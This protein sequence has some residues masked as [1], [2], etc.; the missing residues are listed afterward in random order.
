MRLLPWLTA[1][2]LA[3][4]ALL[5][6]GSVPARAHGDQAISAEEAGA[7]F[8]EVGRYQLLLER[9]TIP[10]AVG[11]ESPLIVRIYDARLRKLISGRKVLLAVKL[12]QV[13]LSESVE[14]AP[15]PSPGLE[16][17]DS[18]PVY[19][20]SP[21][22]W[23][24]EGQPDLSDFEKAVELTPGHYRIF[25]RPTIEGPHFLKIALVGGGT[26][27]EVTLTQFYFQ[28]TAPRG[29]N[30]RFVAASGL[31][32]LMVGVGAAAVGLRRRFPDKR[33]SEINLL[34]L[35]PVRRFFRWRYFQPVFQIPFL[36]ILVLI[37]ILGF[38]DTQ[39]AGK[40]LATRLTW[41]IWWAGVIFTFVLVGRVWCLMCPY[42]AATE[43]T[44]RAVRPKRRFPKPLRNLW[45]ANILFLGLT[46]VD[47]YFGLVGSPRATAWFLL[48]ILL[49]AVGVGA[50]FPRRS[51][52][53]YVCPIGGLIGLYSMFSPVELRARDK[54]VCKADKEFDCYMGN[55][56]G[57]GCP[58]FEDP[59]RMDTNLY[60]SF[61][62]EC[63]K[64]CPKSNMTL[65]L[66]PFAQDLWAKVRGR[67]DEAVL[68]V[69]L[70]G[71][72]LMATGHMISP[73]HRW[74]DSLAALI[75]FR[76]FGIVDHAV[77]ERIMYTLALLGGTGAIICLTWLAASMSRKLAGNGSTLSSGD[78]LKFFGYMFV[79][80]GL[81]AHLS[82][83]LLHLMGE[84]Q[85]VVPVFQKSVNAYTP[86]FLGRPDWRIPPLMGLDAIY[87]LQMGSF[88]VFFG[89]ALF[90]GYRISRQVY[91]DGTMALRALSPM[92]LL[93][94]TFAILNI[95]FLSQGMNPR[96]AH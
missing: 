67:A 90:I 32:L 96:H 17:L 42:G 56:R 73:W 44:S 48:L 38:F 47:G 35:S 40:N 84:A 77:I 52:C 81:A 64:A 83:N 70:V 65:R 87:W 69:A 68:A 31:F 30:G 7:G 89:Y 63:V 18:N 66:R 59:R 22:Q 80:I 26:P 55:E 51:F 13:V 94:L 85:M 25:F 21:F 4:W 43:W 10:F 12:P 5:L 8:V 88:L 36:G 82:H 91:A 3:A 28:V 11:R 72:T 54:L 15:T 86:F 76:S 24:R 41:T 33:W 53:R 46:W 2:L 79:P 92:V 16:R 62:G 45:L 93:A 6:G 74:M 61:C 78:T 29:W 95:F 49:L 14:G 34:D 9:N 19:L 23:T 75:P 27:G 60:C 37:V 58:M 1:S 50:L 39:D 71:V 20:T 57:Y